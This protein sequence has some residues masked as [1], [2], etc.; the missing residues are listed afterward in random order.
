MSLKVLSTRNFFFGRNLETWIPGALFVD[1]YVLAGLKF[2]PGLLMVVGINLL[3]L[4]FVYALVAGMNIIGRPLLGSA[5][6]NCMGGFLVVFHNLLF[7]AVLFGSGSYG[8]HGLLL[9]A[10]HLVA[11]IVYSFVLFWFWKNQ[12]SLQTERL[13]QMNKIM[14]ASEIAEQIVPLSTDGGW[15]TASVSFF[16]P[17]LRPFFHRLL[18]PLAI[19]WIAFVMF[20][21]WHATG[22]LAWYATMYLLLPL[23]WVPR[24]LFWIVRVLYSY[25]FMGRSGLYEFGIVG[26][27]DRIGIELIKEGELRLTLTT[28]FVRKGIH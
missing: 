4:I 7:Q 25:S 12:M 13:F 23:Y 16:F 24:A 19:I 17:F 18:I 26:G 8:Y 11:M 6:G 9:C 2:W 14:T 27:K 28:P 21:L 1:L 10:F 3:S 15:V 22:M 20:M 5:V